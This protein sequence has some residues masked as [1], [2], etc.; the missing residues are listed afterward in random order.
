MKLANGF[1]VSKSLLVAGLISVLYLVVAIKTIVG[2]AIGG[3]KYLQW[4]GAGFFTLPL[5][6][7]MNHGSSHSPWAYLWIY[8]FLAFLNAGLFFFASYLLGMLIGVLFGCL[9]TSRSR[10]DSRSSRFDG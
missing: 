5:S 10:Q 1:R 7:M 4:Y 9:K 3:P 2:C 6:L 8:L